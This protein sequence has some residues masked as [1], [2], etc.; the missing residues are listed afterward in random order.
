MRPPSVLRE[1]IQKKTAGGS[2]RIISN[3]SFSKRG[4]TT[5][6]ATTAAG[7]AVLT[8]VDADADADVDDD[9][10]D[11]H[12]LSTPSWPPNEASSAT[13]FKD[14]VDIKSSTNIIQRSYW[15]RWR[16]QGLSKFN[17]IHL[18]FLWLSFYPVILQLEEEEEEVLGVFLTMPLQKSL[19]ICTFLQTV[20]VSHQKAYHLCNNTNF[21]SYQNFTQKSVAANGWLL[22]QIKTWS[23]MSHHNIR[24]SQLHILTICCSRLGLFA[25][26]Q[27][28]NI[29]VITCTFI[30]I[31][32]WTICRGR[33]MGLFQIQSRLTR[34]I[35]LNL[36]MSKL[37][38][39]VYNNRVFV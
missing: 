39:F 27:K 22:F 33:W 29:M 16:V 26:Y 13:T 11:A 35:T 4:A 36:H 14:F 5:L 25:S 32:N 7:A 10:D 21:H 23:Q 6:V 28:H 12:E 17:R 30:T 24:L 19:V 3:S 2:S 18:I 31:T 37:D 20:C 9:D 8:S 38:K 1:Y 34:P 15:F